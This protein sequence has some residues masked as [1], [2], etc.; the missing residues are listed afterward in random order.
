LAPG[1]TRHCFTIA[2]GDVTQRAASRESTSTRQ[3]LIIRRGLDN[4]ARYCFVD[5]LA[6][7]MRIAKI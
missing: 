3:I 7:P 4:S 5:S 6:A 2:A 1:T